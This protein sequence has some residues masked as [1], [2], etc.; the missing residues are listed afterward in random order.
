MIK[1]IYD[2]CIEWAGYRHAKSFLAFEAFI[3]SSFFPIPPD[4]M[5]VPMVIA[6]RNEFIRIALI[7]TI[8]SVLGALFG[9]FIGYHLN[10]AALKIFEFYGYEHSNTFKEKF[11]L[12]TG[13]KAWLILLFT[14][15]FTPLPF[16]L[17]T[18]SSG[19]INFNLTSFILIC[20]ITRGLRF[21]LVSYLTYKFGVKF[22]PFLEKKGA[23]WSIVIAGVIVIFFIIIFLK[24]LN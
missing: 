5:I 16:K 22:G 11:L 1:K 13:F 6:K 23:S 18:I 10:E 3:E 19:I 4:V 2:K 15:G 24:I 17:L 20:I 14:A 9:Y 7:A 21:F 12:D 8:F